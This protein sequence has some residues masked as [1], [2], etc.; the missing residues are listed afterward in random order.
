MIDS[1]NDG[2]DDQ[3]SIDNGFDPYGPNIANDDPDND[4]WT[5]LDEYRIGS[6]PNWANSEGLEGKFGG[7][8]TSITIPGT[9][10]NWN[11]YFAESNTNEAILTGNAYRLFVIHF[12]NTP[13][14]HEF[15]FTKGD[16]FEPWSLNWGAINSNYS[17]TT[18]IGIENGSNIKINNATGYY[19]IEFDEFTKFWS[20]KPMPLTD[21]NGNGLPDVWEKYYGGLLSNPPQILNPN[22]DYN[23]N[24]RTTLQDYLSGTAPVTKYPRLY[25]TVK[26]IGTPYIQNEYSHWTNDLNAGIEQ[27]LNCKDGIGTNCSSGNR[28][29]D[30]QL[31]FVVSGQNFDNFPL[32]MPLYIQALSLNAGLIKSTYVPDG[33]GLYKFLTSYNQNNFKLT[34]VQSGNLTDPFRLNFKI[35]SIDIDGYEYIT[36]S[37]LA[38]GFDFTINPNN[39][40]SSSSLS[41]SSSSRSS[42]SSSSSSRSSS[43][44]SPSSSSS[45]S[46]SSSSSSLTSS[47]SSSSNSSS[48][49]SSSSIYQGVIFLSFGE[50]S[51]APISSSSSSHSSSSSQSSSSSSSSR[52]SSSSQSSSSSSSS[53]S[54]SSSSSSRSSSSSSSSRSSSSSSSSLS[55]SSSSSS[56]SNSSSSISS[57]IIF[58]S[59]GET[60]SSSSSSSSNPNISSSS[61]SSNPNISSSSSSNPNISSSSSSNPNISSSS[62]SNPNIS[63][64][65]SSSN[66]NI[67]SSSSSSNPNISSS[68]S[69]SL[70][71]SSSSSNPLY[72][73]SSSSS[74]VLPFT[75]QCCRLPWNTVPIASNYS[76]IDIS[77]NGRYQYLISNNL[78]EKSENFGFV[79]TGVQNSNWSGWEFTS[80]ANSKD[81]K[82][83]YITAKNR[84]IQFSNDS[85]VTWQE[86]LNS[87]VKN[88]KSI[89]I[90]DDSKYIG[91]VDDLFIYRS[92]NSGVTWNTDPLIKPWEYISISENG[93]YWGLVGSGTNIYTSNNF[94]QSWVAR[95]SIRNWNRIKIN[96]DGQ[97]QIASVF[98]GGIYT[99]NNYGI[100]WGYNFI[101]TDICSGKI[102]PSANEACCR[103]EWSSGQA[104]IRNWKSVAISEVGITQIAASDY[105]LYV[106]YDGGDNWRII[107]WCDGYDWQSVD[108]SYDGQKMFAAAKN[109][110][111]QFSNNFG[112]TWDSISSNK[113]APK[114][115]ESISTSYEGKYLLVVSSSGGLNDNGSIFRSSDFGNTWLEVDLRP[116]EN[117]NTWRWLSASI[118]ANGQFQAIVGEDLYIYIS[119]DY[120]QTWG[121][122]AFPAKWNRVD[123][124]NDGKY[125]VATQYNGNL[126]ISKN[127]GNTWNLNP[128]VVGQ[129]YSSSSSSAIFC[130]GPN[131]CPPETICVNGLCVSN[132]Y[133]VR[134]KKANF[135]YEASNK[136]NKYFD[137]VRGYGNITKPI[138]GFG[139]GIISNPTGWQPTIIKSTGI[140]SGIVPRNNSFGSFTWNNL[141]LNSTVN[142]QPVYLSYITGHIP[143]ENYII[144]LNNTGLG[145]QIGDRININNINF[146]YNPIPDGLFEFSSPE[147]LVNI[148]NSGYREELDDNGVIKYSIGVSGKLNNNIIILYSLYFSGEEGNNIRV[149]K[150]TQNLDAIKIPFRYFQNGRS[151][152]PTTNKYTSFYSYRNSLTV[153]NSGFYVEK[154]EGESFEGPIKDVVWVDEF[155]NW[156]VRTGL[157]KQ[158]D[159]NYPMINMAYNSGNNLF[160]GN[161]IIPSGNRS[162]F[163]GLNIEILKRAPYNIENNYAFYTLEGSGFM[164]S[165]NL[166]G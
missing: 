125:I 96:S 103:T 38:T 165:G 23:N 8:Y 158:G 100:T 86:L 80:V 4:N 73:S 43:S 114:P 30:I 159:V 46:I 136:F 101:D 150:E 25:I 108:I 149:Y 135:F 139:T 18:G 64:S 62:S 12:G 116:D 51:G 142:N 109:E 3:W 59:F 105:R 61:S 75:Q 126:Y 133:E 97:Y 117:D 42:S 143:A 98:N 102:D 132:R 104:E 2:I 5:N 134:V 26:N 31:N 120:G 39:N 154:F 40:S 78:I 34:F 163:T 124:S 119:N 113:L 138:K 79:W 90:S 70:R 44:S 93:Q 123:I 16:N 74:F 147:N 110:E 111:I 127:Y 17:L 7:R 76:D 57:G 129:C 58:L 72:S 107:S 52:S 14:N 68:S 156:S 145:L 53:R 91:A 60:Y 71:S 20:Y 166:K 151:L 148:L 88:W 54:S 87:P 84:K 50:T 112:V 13:I 6:D 10:N 106:T 29:V 131:D 153:E 89:D 33:I 19:M 49:S 146:Y 36:N 155:K 67:S 162:R 152:R 122:K 77:E 164:Y 81:S 95:D 65:S 118:S 141:N 130:T 161:C 157:F 55:S 82:Y 137:S 45:S 92:D 144:F 85:G 22:V 128:I 66:P 94:G 28:Y 48:S 11:P 41:S 9:W 69:S 63:S 32:E 160:S 99:S 1:N 15:K 83:I 115:W 140:L 121:Q 37:G 27:Q 21:T 24:G 47:N 56:S 35:P